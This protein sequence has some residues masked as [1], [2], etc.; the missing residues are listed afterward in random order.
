[1]L[2]Q[3]AEIMDS[4]LMDFKSGG[5]HHFVNNPNLFGFLKELLRSRRNFLTQLKIEWF[6]MEKF[7]IGF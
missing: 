2:S 5:S 7:L 1:M 4:S 3:L 6:V